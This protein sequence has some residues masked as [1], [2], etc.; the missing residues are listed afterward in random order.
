[1]PVNESGP[2]EAY[3]HIY[4]IG[5]DGS[6]LRQLTQ[7]PYD[8]MMPCYLPDGRIAFT[9]TRRKGYSRCF[10]P[11][12]SQRWHSYT[13]HSIDGDG[14]NLRIL[15]WNDV[16][17][18]FPT[19][20]NKGEILFARWDYIDRDAVTHQNLWAMRPDG[21]NP[22]AVWGNATPKPHC[23]FQARAIPNSNKIVFIGSAH[24]AITAGPVV[25]LDPSVDPNRHEALTRITPGPFPEAESSTIPEYYESPWPLS[26]RLFLVAYSPERLRFQG[27]HPRDP[28]P[29]N[30]LGIYVLDTSGKSGNSCIAIHSSARP[31]RGHTRRSRCRR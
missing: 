12:Y 14:R 28:N 27:E 7:G 31:A 13:L 30:A 15:S 23:A 26:E 1:M 11:E 20:S 8:D 22:V 5:V 29:D 25:V 17:E 16:S 3:F 21:T 9:S 6:G 18:W 2:D 4:E 24:H 10:G 19:V